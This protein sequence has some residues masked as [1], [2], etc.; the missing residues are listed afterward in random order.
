MITLILIF[1]GIGLVLLPFALVVVF[2][3]MASSQWSQRNETDKDQ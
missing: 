1:L 3:C 2:A